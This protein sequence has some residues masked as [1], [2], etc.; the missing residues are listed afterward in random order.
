MKYNAIAP[1]INDQSGMKH[2]INA[3]GHMKHLMN[4][5][6]CCKSGSYT[7]ACVSPEYKQVVNKFSLCK[8]PG[9]F[10]PR[11]YISEYHKCSYEESCASRVLEKVFALTQ[12]FQKMSVVTRAVGVAQKNARRNA[13]DS[14]LDL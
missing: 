8:D 7:T 5:Q 3:Q 4:V 1:D 14:N 10:D 13:L 9:Q 2:L 11:A 6:G 12:M